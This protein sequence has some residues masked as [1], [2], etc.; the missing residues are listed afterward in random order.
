MCVDDGTLIA[1]ADPQDILEPPTDGGYLCSDPISLYYIYTTY[2][3]VRTWYNAMTQ[4]RL[5]ELKY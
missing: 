4:Q 3:S 5:D 1:D 2:D